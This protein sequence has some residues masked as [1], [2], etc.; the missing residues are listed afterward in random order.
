MSKA[1]Y[2]VNKDDR[3]DLDKGVGGC[4]D[5][6]FCSTYFLPSTY[7]A[8]IGADAGD[9]NINDMFEKTSLF[10]SL[11]FVHYLNVGTGEQGASTSPDA[12]NNRFESKKGNQLWLP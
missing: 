8:N 3:I 2:Y 4:R 10:T 6:C 5:H 11:D 7:G 9:K 12:L 1:D